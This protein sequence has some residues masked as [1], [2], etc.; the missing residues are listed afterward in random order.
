MHSPTSDN[1]KRGLLSFFILA[2]VSASTILFVSQKE[3]L[4]PLAA[5]PRDPVIAAFDE[6]VSE[7]HDA[8]MELASLY[9]KLHQQEMELEKKD[10]ELEELA[11][12]FQTSIARSHYFKNFSLQAEA[13]LRDVLGFPLEQ[14]NL[15]PLGGGKNAVKEAKVR[16]EHGTFW[17]EKVKGNGRERGSQTR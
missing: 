4:T 6:V 17:H 11:S 16:A 13:P 9:E 5:Y 14:R 3:S 8:S 10:Q 15:A 7:P 12:L 2:V 1:P